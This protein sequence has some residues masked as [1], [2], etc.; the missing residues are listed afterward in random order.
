[1]RNP[2]LQPSRTPQTQPL[3]HLVA[4]T[5]SVDQDCAQAAYLPNDPQTCSDGPT[6]N[7]PERKTG[8]LCSTLFDLMKCQACRGRGTIGLN[9]SPILFAFTL[10]PLANY[11]IG[12]STVLSP[13]GLSIRCRELHSASFGVAG[14]LPLPAEIIER[15]HEAAKGSVEPTVGILQ[16]VVVSGEGIRLYSRCKLSPYTSG[17]L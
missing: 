15:I 5:C 1:M 2:S 10:W 6:K 7:P 11:S 12:V 8:S 3:H 9:V 17:L 16:S 13:R 4:S 14:F